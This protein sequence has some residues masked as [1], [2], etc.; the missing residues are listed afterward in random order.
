MYIILLKPHGNLWHRES[1]AYCPPLIDGEAQTSSVSFPRLPSKQMSRRKP[2]SHCIR[3]KIS[4]LQG[5]PEARGAQ[6]GKNWWFVLYFGM[7]EQMQ[8][9]H[10]V[11]NEYSFPNFFFFGL[12]HFFNRLCSKG[13]Q[14]LGDNIPRG[15]VKIRAVEMIWVSSTSRDKCH[16]P[17]PICPEKQRT[18]SLCKAEEY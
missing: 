1:R 15:R 5:M 12:F 9:F 4:Q 8:W 3:C 6:E 10:I 7:K 18:P 16:L 17:T 2:K 14:R 13:G 11:L